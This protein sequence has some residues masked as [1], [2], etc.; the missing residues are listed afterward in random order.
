MFQPK[1]FASPGMIV[2]VAIIVFLCLS[3][4]LALT[5][6]PERDEGS[7]WDPAR[8]FATNGVFAATVLDGAGTFRAGAKNHFY[9]QPPGFPLAV[10]LWGSVWG[11]DY[12]TPRTLS[13]VSGA[14]VLASLWF[15]FTRLG[16]TRLCSALALL[17]LAADYFFIIGAANGRM[18]ALTVALGS[19]GVAFWVALHKRSIL[20]AIILGNSLVALAAATHPNAIIWFG[21]LW[22]SIWRLGRGRLTGRLLVCGILPYLAVL[23]AWG[24]YMYKD[25]PSF[26]VQFG[27]SIR[28]SGGEIRRSSIH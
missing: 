28:E 24:L 5:R 3:V 19:A 12:W 7:F 23:G 15:V 10:A 2:T 17:W 16:F 27:G 25:V 11:F 4:G 9:W 26:L 21:V 22:M 13:V 20:Y 6:L 1:L 14:V 18:D 8:N